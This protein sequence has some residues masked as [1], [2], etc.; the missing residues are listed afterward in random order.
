MYERLTLAPCCQAIT[1]LTYG[2]TKMGQKY[3]GLQKKG[4][5]ITMEII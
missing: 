4:A 3:L 2:C 5:K 1:W